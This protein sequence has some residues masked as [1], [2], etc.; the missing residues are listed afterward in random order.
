MKKSEKINVNKARENIIWRGWQKK[1]ESDT[2]NVE[3]AGVTFPLWMWLGQA[4]LPFLA[5]YGGC[6]VFEVVKKRKN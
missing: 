1:T 6:W 4:F 5:V 2:L 3:L